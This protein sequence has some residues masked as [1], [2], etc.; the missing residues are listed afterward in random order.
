MS[1][2]K[3]SLVIIQCHASSYVLCIIIHQWSCRRTGTVDVWW[4]FD[5]GGLTL[6]IPHIVMVG[7]I[8]SKWTIIIIMITF[9]IPR[10]VMICSIPFF[11]HQNISTCHANCH[12]AERFPKHTRML[13]AINWCNIVQTRKRFR[14]CSLRVFALGMQASNYHGQFMITID[15]LIILTFLI[16]SILIVESTGKSTWRGDSQ[17]DKDAWQVPNQCKSGSCYHKHHDHSQH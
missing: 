14:D 6:L 2:H 16:L 5:D 12:G 7:F 1:Y 13:N 9:L 15:V 8:S 3:S 10:V 17:A 4:L 11:Y